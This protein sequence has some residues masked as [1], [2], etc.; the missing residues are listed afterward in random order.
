MTLRRFLLVGLLGGGLMAMGCSLP[1]VG[2]VPVDSQ[3]KPFEAPEEGE[4]TGEGD[5]DDD[6]DWGDLDV[7]D[8]APAA[9][10][11]APAEPAGEAPPTSAAPTG[12][13]TKFAGR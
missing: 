9:K 3:L 4:L 1:P 6:D 8:P 2:K 5:S 13:Q 10:P 11:E 12:G 7:D